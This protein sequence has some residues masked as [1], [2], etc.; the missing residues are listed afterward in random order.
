MYSE[1]KR[2]QG[3]VQPIANLLCSD[4]RTL[5]KTCTFTL[6]SNFTISTKS[7]TLFLSISNLEALLISKLESG[8][9][10]AQETIKNA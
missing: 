8:Q 1:K 2:T 3:N 10:Q 9:G 7:R 6:H 5:K 4:T